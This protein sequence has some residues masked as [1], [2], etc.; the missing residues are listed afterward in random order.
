ML[1]RAVPLYAAALICNFGITELIFIKNGN[2]ALRS[3]DG[4]TAAMF[5]YGNTH[6]DYT[7]DY[8]CHVIYSVVWM[9]TRDWLHSADTL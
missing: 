3:A 5:G 4:T 1:Q 6:Y 7:C 2:M 8:L 9:E